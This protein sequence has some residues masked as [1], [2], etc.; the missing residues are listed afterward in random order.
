VRPSIPPKLFDPPLSFLK[1][2]QLL[3]VLTAHFVVLFTLLVVLL[4]HPQLVGLVSKK[5]ACQSDQK[6]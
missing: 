4:A 3:F 5:W 2:A 6:R 1:L